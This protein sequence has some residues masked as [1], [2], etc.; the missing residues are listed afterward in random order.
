MQ[1]ETPRGSI[2]GGTFSPGRHAGRRTPRGSIGGGTFSP[3]RLAGRRAPRVSIGVG[4]SPQ[5][6]MKA[7]GHQEAA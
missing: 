2:G 3:G 6:G 7:D 4:P 5:A 1:G